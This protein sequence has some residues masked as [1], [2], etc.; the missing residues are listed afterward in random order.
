MFLYHKREEW[1]SVIQ[2]FYYV[3]LHF[4]CSELQQ[5]Y[6]CSNYNNYVIKKVKNNIIVRAYL[7]LSD[8]QNNN[9]LQVNKVRD[10]Y[11]EKGW[12]KMCHIS[13]RF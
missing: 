1:D 7:L 3:W 4:F 2:Q 5:F 13:H 9:G 12:A 8:I 11:V 6:A 10:V